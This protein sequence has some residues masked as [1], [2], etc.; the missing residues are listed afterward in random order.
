MINRATAAV[1]WRLRVS[2]FLS[3]SQ[4]LLDLAADASEDTLSD[5]FTVSVIVFDRPMCSFPSR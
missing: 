5:T 4:S 1:V 2:L 3:T